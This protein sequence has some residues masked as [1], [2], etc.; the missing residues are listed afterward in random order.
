MKFKQ[1]LEYYL[2]YDFHVSISVVALI[3]I[4]YLTYNINIDLGFVAF[5]FVATNLAYRFIRL[6][7]QNKKIGFS[8][9]SQIE[10]SDFLVLFFATFYV[11]IYLIIKPEQ[12]ALLVL[13][14]ILSIIY[15]I[16]IIKFKS[17]WIGLRE[18]PFFKIFYI[19]F[20]WSL[21]THI[22]P[23]LNLTSEW[24]SIGLLRRFIFIIA[25]T[26]PFDIRDYEVDKDIIYTIP[27]KI[28]INKSKI[29]GILLIIVNIIVIMAFEDISKNSLIEIFVMIIT[30]IM[31][32][33]SDI[34]KSKYYVT[35]WIESIP[36]CW[37]IILLVLS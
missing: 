35:F 18:F 19:A 1:I 32:Y 6:A 36:I 17:K 21:F 31:I 23:V 26:I 28:G 22:F 20:V 25:L 15:I 7:D 13:I 8:S 34:V 2:N 33:Y 27:H 4:T 12:F 30:A 10:K 11:S 14:V 37:L 9:I 24:F 3:S 16:P 5:G 29:F